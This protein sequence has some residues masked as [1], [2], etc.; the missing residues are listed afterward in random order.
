MAELSV[1][2]RVQSRLLY[3]LSFAELRTS[4]ELFLSSA[5]LSVD[6]FLSRDF[7]VPELM[8]SSE[9]TEL[10]G[11]YSQRDFKP[12]LTEHEFNDFLIGDKIDT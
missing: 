2:S 1:V 3:L 6:T 4:G 5:V 8:S 10:S 9:L 12:R 11:P 7:C